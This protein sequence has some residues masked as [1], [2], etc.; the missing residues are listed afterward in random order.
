M[1]IVKVSLFTWKLI[2]KISNCKF[3]T[4][5]FVGFNLT[6]TQKIRVKKSKEVQ[7]ENIKQTVIIATGYN[8]AASYDENE[9]YIFIIPKDEIA[10]DI[11]TNFF[12]SVGGNYTVEE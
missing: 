12:S 10:F 4:S 6:M 1:L 5:I 11:I 7:L 3:L 2:E 9:D 8:N